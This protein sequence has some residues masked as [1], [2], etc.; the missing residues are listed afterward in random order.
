[1]VLLV[2]RWVDVIDYCRNYF[3]VTKMILNGYNLKF[4]T[5]S[6]FRELYVG[7]I[8]GKNTSLGEYVGLTQNVPYSLAK[9][10]VDTVVP[11]GHFVSD[12]NSFYKVYGELGNVFNFTSK[13]TDS[14]RSLSELP[15]V[16]IK[17]V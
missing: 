2:D 16:Q 9:E 6:E 11:M 17:K 15:Y 10:I 7:N 3:K 13:P 14:F 4:M 5:R 1:M 12:T 8:Q